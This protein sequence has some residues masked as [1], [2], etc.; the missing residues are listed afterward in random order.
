MLHSL[1]RL[2]GGAHHVSFLHVEATK[3]TFQGSWGLTRPTIEQAQAWFQPWR[4]ALLRRVMDPSLAGTSN[5]CHPATCPTSQHW[6]PA[7]QTQHMEHSQT[8]RPWKSCSQSHLRRK[9]RSPRHGGWAM[10]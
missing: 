7:G 6:E 5:V 1:N 9:A 8:G 2:S 10:N 4:A 3:A